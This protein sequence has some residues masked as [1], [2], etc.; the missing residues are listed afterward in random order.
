MSISNDDA[1][2]IIERLRLAAF[3]EIGPNGPNGHY[4]IRLEDAN[5][6]VMDQ[7]ENG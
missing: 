3:M 2:E 6:I 1:A 5:L 7:T 4:L